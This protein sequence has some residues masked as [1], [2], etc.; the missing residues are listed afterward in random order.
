MPHMR[1]APLGSRAQTRTRSRKGIAPGHAVVPTFRRCWECR[2]ATAGVGPTVGAAGERRTDDR[3]GGRKVEIAP[4][5]WAISGD[6]RRARFVLTFSLLLILRPR[7]RG[8]SFFLPPGVSSAKNRGA[9]TRVPPP[10]SSPSRIRWVATLLRARR[11]RA[12]DGH[13]TSLG[14]RPFPALLLFFFF[15]P[16]RLTVTRRKSPAA[17]AGSDRSGR[18]RAVLRENDHFEN[19]PRRR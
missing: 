18:P 3:W 16:C 2:L 1:Y 17:R 10:V 7:N 12:V 14:V 9:P 6:F 8:V 4:G 5:R 19:Y 13:R 15:H 11:R